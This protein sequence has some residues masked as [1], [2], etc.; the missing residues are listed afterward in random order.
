[1]E[2]SPP[3]IEPT[4]KSASRPTAITVIC[5]FGFIGAALTIP[6]IFSDFARHIGSWYPPYLAF[7]AIV[8]FVCMVGL[9]KMRRWA[10]FTYTGFC[11]INQIVMIAMGVWSIFALLIPG[12]IIALA[13]SKLSK[14]R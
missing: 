11:A 10:V 8:G 3:P 2:T 13:F 12:I 1:M 7:S 9:W 6:L 5:V 14:M 4:A